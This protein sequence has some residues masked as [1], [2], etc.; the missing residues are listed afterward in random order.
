MGSLDEGWLLEV[1]VEVGVE[2][3]SLLGGPN[4]TSD[5]ME[6]GNVLLSVPSGEGRNVGRGVTTASGEE[7]G[8]FVETILAAVVVG[9]AVFVVS[10]GILVTTASREEEGAFVETILATIVVGPVIL[11]ASTGAATGADVT[12][13][14]LTGAELMGAAVMGFA[15][16]SLVSGEG[17]GWRVL[18]IST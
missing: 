12:G 16:G 3:G 6:A 1:G 2:V 18:Q 13:A 5:A 17:D 14:A 4:I 10:T 8:A 15:L 7:D 11:V 9:L